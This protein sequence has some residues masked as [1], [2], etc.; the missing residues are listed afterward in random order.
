M[1]RTRLNW[2][3]M[4]GEA[5]LIVV[6]VFVAI[7]LEGLW[8]ERVQAGEARAALGQL[9]EELKQDRV[10]LDAVVARQSEIDVLWG[11]ARAWLA[12]PDTLPSDEFHDALDSIVLD[13]RTLYVRRSAW[14]NLVTNS[15][16]PLLKDPVLVGH[17]SDHY[18]NRNT[19]LDLNNN[20]YD[21]TAMAIMRESATEIWDGDNRVL[22]TTDALA[23]SIFRGKIR[24]LHIVWNKWYLDFMSDYVVALDQLIAD[25]ESYLEKYGD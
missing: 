23:L 10:S 2:R 18:E 7:V 24:H 6:S 3:R 8:Q 20:M 21:A 9:L 15:H 17:L 1:S 19:I 13:N 14:A 22:L 25:V 4:A 11:N 5:T 16:L 12:N